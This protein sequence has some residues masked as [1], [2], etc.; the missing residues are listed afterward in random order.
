MNLPDDNNASYTEDIDTD[1]FHIDYV[2]SKYPQF[3][4]IDSCYFITGKDDAIDHHN[5]RLKVSN[6]WLEDFVHEGVAASGGDTIKI[7]NT[8]ALNNDQGFEAG[9]TDGGVSKGPFVFVDHCVAVGNRIDGLRVGDNYTSTYKDV[10]KV[11]NTI[12]YN[13]RDH[14]IW[15]YLYSTNAPLAGAIDIS[16]SMTND[17]VYDTS[18][19]CITG[20]PQFNPYY[21]LLP[22]SPGIN[23]GM[24]GTNMGRADSTAITMGVIVINEI[25]YNA[26]SAMDSKDWI[27][28][29]NP[30]SIAQDISGW[31]IK[32]EDSTHTFNIPAGVI[33]PAKDYWLLC[34]DTVAFK[35]VYQNVNSYTG[36][37]PFGFGG[38]DQVRLYTPEGWLVDSVAYNN[39]APWPSDADGTGYTIVLLD[40]T[41]DHTLPTNWN[42]SNQ[43]GGTP[44]RPNIVS[45][46]EASPSYS[47]PSQYS[48]EQNYPNPFNPTTNIHFSIG[49]CQ[50]VNLKIFD[51][52]GREVV[53]LVNEEKPAG[54]YSVTWDA[55]SFSSGVYF[56]RLNAGSYINTKKLIL[57]K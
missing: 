18:P 1:G 3:S 22:G 12:V 19:F 43:Y 16:Y 30:Q 7:F 34:G 15:N 54:K 20:V 40:A 5:S 33:I 31:I 37:I 21:Y 47:L 24:R 46:V 35:Q 14:N 42:R 25:M 8:V 39:N 2:N 27:E 51:L 53:V 9:N 38:K 28:L 26:P 50:F 23:M 49:N 32:D 55:S 13:N 48:L 44:G 4:I 57:L 17:S 41:K 11:T 10:L 56:Y 36:N 45:D 29:Y 6:C 52:L